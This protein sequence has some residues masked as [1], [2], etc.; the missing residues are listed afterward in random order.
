MAESSGGTLCPVA[1]TD[2]RRGAVYT[3]DPLAAGRPAEPGRCRDLAK[4]LGGGCGPGACSYS[5]SSEVT[6]SKASVHGDPA[7]K[8]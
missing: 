4:I 5:A 7:A 3:I 6:S 2:G 8:R 1:V